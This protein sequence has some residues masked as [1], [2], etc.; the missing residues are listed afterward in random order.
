MTDWAVESAAI[1]LSAATADLL[2]CAWMNRRSALTSFFSLVHMRCA[3]P[4][5]DFEVRVL[6]ELGRRHARRANRYDSIALP[7]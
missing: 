6:D 5:V 3:P 7:G 4:P 1:M 2:A